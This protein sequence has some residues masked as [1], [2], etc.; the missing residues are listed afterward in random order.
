MD[1]YCFD[2]LPFLD[3]SPVWGCLGVA[4]VCGTCLLRAE[5]TGRERYPV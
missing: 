3:T 1:R 4:L 5:S 2:P